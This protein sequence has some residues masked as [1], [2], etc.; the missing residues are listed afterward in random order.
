MSFADTVIV[1]GGLIANGAAGNPSPIILGG[2]Y[3]TSPPTLANGDVSTDLV[4]INGNKLV[5]VVNAI[6]GVQDEALFSAGAS[7]GALIFAAVN[8]ALSAVGQGDVAALRATAQRLLMV[9]P[10]ASSS[11]GWLPYTLNAPASP[12][13]AAQIIKA[14][15]GQ[16]GW[17]EVTNNTSAFVWVKIYNATVQNTGGSA[18]ILNFGVPAGSGFSLAAPILCTIGICLSV[19][20]A[21]QND[22][23]AIAGGANTVSVNLGYL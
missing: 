1:G 15:P 9:A 10:G 23:A 18:W 19:G 3:V 7:A 12:G 16:I 21:L 8:D 14:S 22:T 6:Q 13:A 2:R 11:G 17:M 4:D 20:G 5:S